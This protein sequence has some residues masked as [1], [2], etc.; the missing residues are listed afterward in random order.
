MRKNK[1]R[2]IAPETFLKYAI[3]TMCGLILFTLVKDKANAERVSNSVGGEELLLLLPVM[4]WLVEKTIK[5]WVAEMK[6]AKRNR[7][8]RTLR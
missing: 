4:W 3:I 1:K 2:T 6:K 7:K 5:D 8:E